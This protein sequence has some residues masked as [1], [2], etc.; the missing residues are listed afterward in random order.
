M[1]VG[2]GGANVLDRSGTSVRMRVV[3]SSGRI[4]RSRNL[5]RGIPSDVRSLGGHVLAHVLP[6]DA[7]VRVTRSGASG[8]TSGR[9]LHAG[10]QLLRIGRERSLRVGTLAGGVVQGAV[11]LRSTE[12]FG[13]VALTEPDGRGGYVVV[14]RVWTQAPRTAD[15]FQVIH[16][17]PS[18]RILQTFAVSSAA[19]AESPPMGRFRLGPD[20]DL[21]Q[22]VTGADGIRI[23]R[24]DLGEGRR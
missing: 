8:I 9:P 24:F 6:L 19:F 11:E 14:V 20:G 10:K 18:G 5:G 1:A 21:Y 23:V 15:Q 17:G 22:L 3:D 2:A 12:R 4:G 16:L 13:E 7:W